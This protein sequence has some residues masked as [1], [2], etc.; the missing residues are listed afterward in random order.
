MINFPCFIASILLLT[1]LPLQK[2]QISWGISVRQYTSCIPAILPTGTWRSVFIRCRWLF[3]K[4]LLTI[5]EVVCTFH[6]TAGEFALLQAWAWRCAQ[7]D[8]FRLCEGS[9]PDKQR[10][11][12][13]LL[14]SLLRR[15]VCIELYIW[16]E[17]QRILNKNNKWA[18]LCCVHSSGDPE[19]REIRQVVWYV[20]AW[21]YSLHPVNIL[22]VFSVAMNII[23]SQVQW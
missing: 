8:R 9:K 20:V 17:S 3:S 18:K 22:A 1:Y 12:D 23:S 10:P 13:T 15:S 6:C 2:Q 19:L 21:R 16:F 5:I 14:Y 11:A 4:F 7:V